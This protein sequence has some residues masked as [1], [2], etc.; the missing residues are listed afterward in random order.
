MSWPTRTTPTT[1]RRGPATTTRRPTSAADRVPEERLQRAL[2]RAGHG[3]RRACEQLIADGEGHRRR[4]GRDPRRQGRPARDVGRGRRRALNLDPNVRYYALHKPPG[5]VTTMHD[6]QGRPDLRGYLPEGPAGVPGRP[7]GPRLARAS[8]CS[9]TTGSSRTGSCIRATASRRSTSPRCDGPPTPAA[10]RAPR[11]RRPR[12]RSGPRRRAP[13]SSRPAADRGQLRLVMTEGRKRE[14]RRMLA[15]VDLPVTRLVR[16]RIGPITL[17]GI[18]P[19][20]VRE[21]DAGRGR[22][23]SRGPPTGAAA[24][25]R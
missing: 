13:A 4:E 12:G 20:E 3:S 7:A 16:L 19:G 6:A 9:R 24:V 18:P 14:V 23:P 10:R 21:L 25:G 22:W 2:A 1:R 5:V 17:G 8:C 15:A 11:G